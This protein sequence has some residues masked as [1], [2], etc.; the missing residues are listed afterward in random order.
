MVDCDCDQFGLGSRA[1]QICAGESELPG[2]NSP[3]CMCVGHGLRCRRGLNYA[4]DLV[5]GHVF[6][7]LCLAIGPAYFEVGL[8]R[9]AQAEVQPWIMR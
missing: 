4:Q 6:N 2:Y 5:G 1:Y 3:A 8:S 7:L 9:C